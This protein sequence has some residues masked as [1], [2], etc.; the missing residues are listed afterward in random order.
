MR[1]PGWLPLCGVVVLA[2]CAEAPVQ[3]GAPDAP[4]SAASDAAATAIAEHREFARRHAQAGDH[5]SA[6]REWRIVLLLAPGDGAARKEYDAE[7]AAIRQGVRD[8]LLAGQTAWRNGDAERATQAML[9]VLA[10]DPEKGEAA[11]VLREIDRQKLVRIQAAQAQRAARDS[12]ANAAVAARDVLANAAA[13]ARGAPAPAASEASEPYDL[14]Q[15]IEMFKAGDVNGGLRDFRAFVDANP[16]NDAARQRVA[17]IVYDRAIETEQKGAHE[18]ALMLVEQAASLRGR[19]VAEWSARAQALRKTLSADYYDRG[20]QTFR[21]DI[22][23]AIKL[24]ET[25]L[26]YD[27]QNK[28][29]QAKLAEARGAQDKLKRVERETKAK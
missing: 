19:P 11:K 24:W 23:G 7:R 1:A 29:A 6:A 28:L 17:S 25:S 27:P 26:R 22:G 18:Q 5:A 10:L 2:A 8:N 21:S 4:R 16:G 14:E 3:P 15:A 12:Q 13:A 20:V 9:K